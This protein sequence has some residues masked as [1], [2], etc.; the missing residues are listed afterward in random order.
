M[1]KPSRAG[2]KAAKARPRKVLKRKGRSAPKALS[3]RAAAPDRETEIVRLTRELN[4]A[5][6]QQTATGNV[7]KVISRSSFDLQAALD[8]LVK[9]A[10]WL[11][12]AELV[13]IHHHRD[14]VMQFSARF[15]LP[16]E[17]EEI[18]KRNPIA[19]GRGTVT[20]RVLLGGKPVQISDVKAD[21]E[22][23]FAEGQKAGRFRTVL[24]VPLEREGQIIGVIVLARARV[25][26]FTD[27]QIGLVQNF[28]AQAVIAIENARLLNELRESLQEQTATAEVLQVISSSPGD[29]QPVFQTMLEK[30]VRICDAT[31]GNIYRWEG[32]TLHLLA[33]HNTPPALAEAR[34]HSPLRP[35]PGTPVDLMVA[36]K[37]AFHADIAA[38]Q[39]YIDRS[40]PG[41]IAAVE[42]GGVR[43]AFAE[44]IAPAHCRLEPA[45]PRTY[46]IAGATD[47]DFGGAPGY[48][49][50]SRRP[51]AGV[52]N[53]AGECCAGLRRDV[54]KH[55]WLGWRNP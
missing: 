20:G 33:S 16:Q 50:L 31:F 38:S 13:A 4:E 41:A 7:L 54:W 30:A 45:H 10:A 24:G 15:G 32:E 44:R 23:T 11:C 35:H 2:G 29:L 22:Y 14:G 12:E 34:K 43:S 53:H 5:F 48:Q 18:T 40:D 46:R 52:C 27:R 28:A 51:R 8:T 6:E 47:S 3:H 26:P 42:L 25:F 37:A 55:L 19:P 39:G 1:T 17:W 21:P 9:L 36:N 49:Q